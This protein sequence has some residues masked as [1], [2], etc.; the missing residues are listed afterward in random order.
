MRK[1]KI[2]ITTVVLSLAASAAHA[3]TGVPVIFEA[4]NRATL[5]AEREGVLTTFDVDTGKRVKKGA[6]LARV[7]AGDLALQKKRHE[8]NLKFLKAQLDNLS[9]LNAR[10]LA[11]DEEV[12]KAKMESGV[13][14]TDIEILRRHIIHSRIVAPFTGVVVKREVQPH[15]WVTAGQPVV[16]LVDPQ[17]LRVV[18][19]VFSEDAVNIKIGDEHRV[20]VNAIGTDVTAKVKAITPAVDEQS[21]TVLVVWSVVSGHSKLLAGM[22]GELFLK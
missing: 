1:M 13:T 4:E 15:E 20:H 6:V 17:S 22:K 7:D 8:L 10:G 5:S 18:G 2:V 11:T 21:N 14:Q 9:K 3:L 19:N 16:E 12:A